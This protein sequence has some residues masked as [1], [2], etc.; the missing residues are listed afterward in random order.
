MT[1]LIQV[2]AIDTQEIPILLSSALAFWHNQRPLTAALE[3]AKFG[4]WLD[5]SGTAAYGLTFL[6]EPV[7]YITPS[8]V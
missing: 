5:R 6:S 1:P 2:P 7:L 8:F 4:A 3:S